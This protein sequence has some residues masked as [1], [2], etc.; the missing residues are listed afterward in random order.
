M[1]VIGNSRIGA[2][3]DTDASIVWCCVPRFDGDPVFC[4]LA[5][6]NAREG[7]FDIALEGGAVVEQA[8]ERNSAVLRSVARTGNGD[9]IEIIDFAPRFL[10]R[11]RMFAPVTLVRI[12]RPLSGRPRVSVRFSPRCERGARMA[13]LSWGSHHIRA[14]VPEYPLRLTTD[15]PLTPVIEQRPLIVDGPLTF[16]L[17]PDETLAES[18]LETGRWML[19]QTLVYWR[20]WVRN[21]AIPFEWQDAVIRAAITLKLNTFDDTGAVIAALTTSIP[22]A[23]DSGRNWDYRFCWLRDAYFVIN[24]LNRLGSTGSMERYLRYLEGI[25]ADVSA[26]AGTPEGTPLQPVY[27]LSGQ[28]EL[29]EREEPA[30]RGFRG[31]GPVRTGNLAYAQRQHDAYGAAILGVAHAFFDARLDRPGD[32][33]LLAEL[34]RLGERAFALHD[35]PDA[36][37]WEFRGRSAVHTFSALMCWAAC[38][39]LA[40]ICQRR[41]HAARA[42][43]WRDR[44]DTVRAAIESR[45]WNPA[46]NAFVAEMPADGTASDMLDASL[47]LM[48]ELDFLRGDDPR[49]AGTVRAIE[50]QLRR[51][52]FLLRYDRPDDFGPP[53]TAF[54]V[55]T[56]WWVQALALIGERE[57]AREEFERLL[58]CRNRFGLLSEDIDAASGELWGNYPQTYSMVGIIVCAMR[59]SRRWDDAF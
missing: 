14:Q 57:R 25:I 15:A 26:D 48:G 2:L 35:V 9:A 58:A 28:A 37:I 8:Y 44:A 34:E 1:A 23:R 43:H 40:R 5:D 39:R 22:E 7:R 6:D 10:L 16:I 29:H 53:E 46:R 12:V 3:I 42:A 59:L 56:F 36:G 54:L 52:D 55:C 41:G 47:L 11:G 31:M 45:G 24:A 30:L 27:G 17:G 13:P 49:L 33:A 4:A 19:E 38:D 21:L 50:Q 18:P 20:R 32:D 51:G